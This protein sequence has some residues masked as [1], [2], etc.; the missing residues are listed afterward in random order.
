MT[1]VSRTATT[2]RR[3]SRRSSFSVTKRLI[4]GAT[5]TGSSSD[6]GVVTTTARRSSTG[7]RLSRRRTCRTTSPRSGRS[8]LPTSSSSAGE[9]G[10]LG[11]LGRTTALRPRGREG[12]AEPRRF[13]IS[14]GPS[15][16]CIIQSYLKC[17]LDSR[18]SARGGSSFG[19]RGNDNSGF[20]FGNS[21]NVIVVWITHESYPATAHYP[22]R[23]RAH[24]LF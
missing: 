7:M 16:F 11:Q 21:R 6:L 15:Y 18:L 5:S 3:R 24:Q 4:R 9:H 23:S 8:T 17:I 20:S 2:G 19:G 10:H 14:P 12:S 13:A 22:H 1:G